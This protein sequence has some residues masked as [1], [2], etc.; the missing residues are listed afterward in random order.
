MENETTEENSLSPEMTEG[1]QTS[2]DL[3][4]T[5]SAFTEKENSLSSNPIAEAISTGVYFDIEATGEA[6]TTAIGAKITKSTEKESVSIS[7][8]ETESENLGEITFEGFGDKSTEAPVTESEMDVTSSTLEEGLNK[9]SD[10]AEFEATSGTISEVTHITSDIDLTLEAETE[11]TKEN[12]E[13]LV[14][15]EGAEISSEPNTEAPETLSSNSGA[16]AIFTTEDLNIEATDELVSI[17]TAEKLT[18]SRNELESELTLSSE[19]VTS[20]TMTEEDIGDKYTGTVSIKS[21]MDATSSFI[22]EDTGRASESMEVV[23]SSEKTSDLADKTELTQ[24]VEK[25]TTKENSESSKTTGGGDISSNLNAGAEISVNSTPIVE[26][27]ENLSSRDSISYIT[28]AFP[29]MVIA[30]ETDEVVSKESETSMGSSTVTEIE[31]MSSVTTSKIEIISSKTSEID[32][33]VESTESSI[34][35][36]NSLETDTSAIEVTLVSTDIA[37]SKMI[38]KVESSESI[39]SNITF[40]PKVITSSS[41]TEY[42]S[43]S[44]DMS[45]EFPSS[46]T[47]SVKETKSE[48][49]YTENSMSSGK[50]GVD[51]KCSESNI[52]ELEGE[53]TDLVPETHDSADSSDAIPAFPNADKTENLEYTELSTVG[54]PETMTNSLGLSTNM[55]EI[56]DVTVVSEIL[57][58]SESLDL[59]ST[60]AEVTSLGKDQ[61]TESSQEDAETSEMSSTE[62][63]EETSFE[64][65]RSTGTTEGKQTIATEMVES[66][67]NTEVIDDENKATEKRVGD[68]ILPLVTEGINQSSPIG[69]DTEM[70]STV[71]QFTDEMTNQEGVESSDSSST[72]EIGETIL[73]TITTNAVRFTS[74]EFANDIVDVISSDAEKTTTVEPVV[75]TESGVGSEPMVSKIIENTL[76]TAD[77]GVNEEEILSSLQSESASEKPLPTFPLPT[78]GPDCDQ[79]IIMFCQM[80]S[81]AIIASGLQVEDDDDTLTTTTTTEEITTTEEPT[82]TSVPNTTVSADDENQ[83][84][85]EIS[86]DNTASSLSTI[87]SFTSDSIGKVEQGYLIPIVDLSDMA[88][89]IFNTKENRIIENARIENGYLQFENGTSILI[90]DIQGISPPEKTANNVVISV[91]LDDG[92][93]SL[94][95]LEAGNVIMSRKSSEGIPREVMRNYSEGALF[96]ILSGNTIIQVDTFNGRWT[97]Q[98][99]STGDIHLVQ[100]VKDGILYLANGD[101]ISLPTAEKENVTN[102]MKATVTEDSAGVSERESDIN[103]GVEYETTPVTSGVDKDSTATEP[104]ETSADYFTSQTDSSGTI[105]ASEILSYPFTGQPKTEISEPVGSESTSE[106]P[107]VIPE[108]TT[109][110]ATTTGGENDRDE[111][112]SEERPNRSVATQVDEGELTDYPSVTIPSTVK[113]PHFCESPAH[114][115]VLLLTLLQFRLAELVQKFRENNDEIYDNLFAT[116]SFLRVVREVID[117]Y[118]EKPGVPERYKPNCNCPVNN[119]SCPTPE[120]PLPYN[121]TPPSQHILGALKDMSNGAIILNNKTALTKI[122]GSLAIGSMVYLNAEDMF[123]LKVDQN[124]NIWRTIDMQHLMSRRSKRT[125]FSSLLTSPKDRKKTEIM[126]KRI[127]RER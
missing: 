76:S 64:S 92:T 71:D 86:S 121:V 58:S 100:E 5:Y 17:A 43:D 39:E 78:S 112:V 16:K 89:R 57:S 30:N 21:E 105:G 41:E 25:N 69:P 47:S 40:S 68:L 85:D 3:S 51:T 98:D 55:N 79:K 52:Q 88:V 109:V 99:A 35:E 38:E 96:E 70:T 66:D 125:K 67:N 94:V 62:E 61:V 34:P 110:D 106:S 116:P 73:E 24:E 26:T 117:E 59:R 46:I 65:V 11:V 91:D 22:T 44:S 49:T 81:R 1:T 115:D 101:E 18:T 13:S 120:P 87:I 15:Y 103:E 119:C 72:K 77:L 53:G 45:S 84:T 14:T 95:D 93:T 27:D 33:M 29:T 28:E 114:F 54:E 113:S 122:A 36:F 107:E 50:T 123:Y 124:E 8:T 90:Q 2:L 126:I 63:A 108:A 127:L 97:V 7:E 102:E 60:A 10:S 9:S 20:S 111:E 75:G 48:M 37:S 12:F 118:F 4:T 83:S 82:T 32:K 74:S 6:E 42:G 23:V 104:D 19:V 31:G 80:L 56:E